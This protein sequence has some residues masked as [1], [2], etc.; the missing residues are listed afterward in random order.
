MLKT[1]K[2]K[3]T[4]KMLVPKK[5]T[6]FGILSIPKTGRVNQPLVNGI[7][8]G[9]SLSTKTSISFPLLDKVDTLTTSQVETSSLRLK[10]VEQPRNGTSINL[11]ELSEVDQL[12]NQSKSTTLENRTTCN[13]TAPTPTGGRCSSSRAVI[14]SIFIATR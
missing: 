11:Q 6:K 9:A 10:M 13:T 4:S 14:L 1:D 8:I 5:S 3:C 2:F 12:T 7:E